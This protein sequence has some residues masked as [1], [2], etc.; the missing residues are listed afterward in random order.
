[1]PLQRRYEEK[2]F[3]VHITLSD[4][5]EVTSEEACLREILSQIDEGTDEQTEITFSEYSFQTEPNEDGR[6]LCTLILENTHIHAPPSY[7][8]EELLEDHLEEVIARIRE[9]ENVYVNM[10][11]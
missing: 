9:Y 1:M 10:N 5:I 3:I 8:T 6:T 2:T 4:Y 7:Y 11:K